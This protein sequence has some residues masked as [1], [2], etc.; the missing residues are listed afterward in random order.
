MQSHH[1]PLSFVVALAT[2][3]F[4]CGGD[5][6]D[7]APQSSEESTAAPET[8]TGSQPAESSTGGSSSSGGAPGIDELASCDEADLEILP[9]MGPAFD[10]ET[11][12]LLA[13]LPQPHVVATTV[14]WVASPEEWELVGPQ[15]MSAMEDVFQR[16]GLLG[17]SF[18]MS[19][20]C[21]AARTITLWRDEA[22][23][24]AF[25]L[26]DAHAAAI[27][28][29]LQHTIGWETTHWSET[30]SDEPPTWDLVRTKLDQA[31]Q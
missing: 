29:G 28:N 17:A 16:E 1:V 31:R 20:E 19:S 15:T 22:A 13:P 4:A 9:F 25:V 12:E 27:Q 14:G 7:A 21:G 18:G 11:G 26:G 30:T 8:S 3:A 5:D 10:P 23:L 2:L 24:M 6:H